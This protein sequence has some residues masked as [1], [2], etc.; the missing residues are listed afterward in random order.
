MSAKKPAQVTYVLKVPHEY[1]DATG[2][3]ARKF[4]PYVFTSLRAAHKSQ[5]DTMWQWS[6]IERREGRS[7][8]V[9]RKYGRVGECIWRAKR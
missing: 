1:D 8:K 6:H 4:H 7:R 9:I 3:G 5:T 2:F